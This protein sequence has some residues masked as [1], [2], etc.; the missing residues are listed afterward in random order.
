MNTPDGPVVERRGGCLASLLVVMILASAGSTLLYLFAPRI[1]E[2]SFPG[3]NPIWRLVYAIGSAL[4]VVFLVLVWQWQKIGLF[5]L[6][7]VSL[8]ILVVNVV[9]GLPPML[10]L[11]GVTGPLLVGILVLPKWDAFR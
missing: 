7:A 2:A 10:A 11:A 1:F 8:F 3:A 4:N 9:L 6:V 5:A